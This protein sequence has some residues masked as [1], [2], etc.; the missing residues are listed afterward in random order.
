MKNIY[1]TILFLSLFSCTVESISDEPAF[2]K[3]PSIRILSVSQDT[4]VQFQDSLVL[5]IE[6]E[7]GDGDL[8]IADPDVNSIFVQDSRLENPDE[9]YLPPLAPENA[10]L[11]ITGTFDLIL[12]RTFLLGNG[13]EETTKFTIHL[14]DRA[15]NQSNVVETDEIL[16]VK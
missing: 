13:T 1:Y 11:S 8:G 10:V 14:F 12:S 4:L 15:G 7:D 6:Y 5:K 2:D 9:Y 16:I 3:I